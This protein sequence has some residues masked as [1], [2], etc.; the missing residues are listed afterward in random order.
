M[1]DEKKEVIRRRLHDSRQA[2]LGL[3]QE[4]DEA[5]W[6][7]PVYSHD[8]RWTALD[9]LRHLTWAESGMTRLMKLIREGNEGVPPDFDLDRYN[10][11]GVRK[12]KEKSATELLSQMEEN[13]RQLLDL[14]QDLDESEWHKQ[15]RHGSLR[16]M[17]I[18]EI[19]QQCADH[20]RQHTQDIRQALARE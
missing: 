9:V 17:T 12:L 1:T 7:H 3:V 15:G 6:T 18:E 2:L 8:A 20:E 10:K 14:I 13:R 11:S 16:I 4:M 5:Q 19:C